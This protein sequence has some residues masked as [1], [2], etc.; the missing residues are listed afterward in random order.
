MAGIRPDRLSVSDIK[1]RLLNVAHTSLYRLT[2][3]VPSGVRTFV[4][5]RGISTLDIDNIS[6]LC[7]EANLPGSTL[8]TH[9]VTNDYHGVSEKMVYRRMYDETADMTFYVD[10]DYKVVEF[11]ESW[12]DYITG[13]GDTFTR[14]EFKSP[15]VHHRMEYAENYKIN[16]YLSKFE[17]DHHFNGSSKTLDYTFVY[18]FPISITA[19]PVS[20]DQSQVLK[21]NISFSFI[22]Y[23]MQRSGTSDVSVIRNPNAPGVS[24]LGQ[25]DIGNDPRFEIPVTEFNTSKIGR[26]ITNEYYNNGIIRG[27]TP[28]QQ[29]QGPGQRQQDATNFTRD[30]A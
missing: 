15:Y 2:I 19:M 29:R 23:V 7:T 4:S 12:I 17:K 24:E 9:D 1:S 5:Q 21:C 25:F 28:S 11:F 6:L 8:A 20:Y 18:G 13:I 26:T 14:E 30:I 10:R 16:F 22:R 3:P 27:L